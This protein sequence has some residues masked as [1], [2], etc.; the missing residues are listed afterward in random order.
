MKVNDGTMTSSP[1]PMPGGGGARGR[2]VVHEVVATPCFAPTYAATA[3]SN[4]ATLGPWVTHP[5]LIDSYGARA[6]SSVSAGLVIGTVIF[7]S[8][9]ISIFDSSRGLLGSGCEGLAPPCDQLFDSIAEIRL[10]GESE[11]V[12][13]TARVTVATG[14]KR[15]SGLRTVLHADVASGDI[16]KDGR[17]IAHAGLDAAANVDDIVDRFGIAGEKVRARDVS[18]VDEVDRGRA[19]PEQHERLSLVDKVEPLDH[20]LDVRRADVL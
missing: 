14:W 1:G 6:S 11:Q 12:F 19:V 4:S 15:S 18:D 16:Q 3:F 8:Y 2:P 9:A 13:G 7:F 10:C 17:E 5:L 20:H